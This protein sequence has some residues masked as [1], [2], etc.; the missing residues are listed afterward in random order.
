MI[1][2]EIVDKVYIELLIVEF[3]LKIIR[4]EKFDVFLLIL[5]G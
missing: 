4:K 5:G 1:D 2:K 3:L